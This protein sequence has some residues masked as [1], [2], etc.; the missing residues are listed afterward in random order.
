MPSTASPWSPK[1][2]RGRTQMARA[3]VSS[4]MF[5]HSDIN[6]VNA[7]KKSNKKDGA[8]EASESQNA[9]QSQLPVWNDNS[10]FN[11]DVSEILAK[12]EKPAVG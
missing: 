6:S 7:R 2:P 11:L 10:K 5:D 1:M 3:S 12:P 8:S 9:S 4:I